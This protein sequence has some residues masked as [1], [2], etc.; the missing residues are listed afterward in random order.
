[1]NNL[2]MEILQSCEQAIRQTISARRSFL[3]GGTQK[4]WKKLHCDQDCKSSIFKLF[5]SYR[6]F[7][8][9]YFFGNPGHFWSRV[10]KNDPFWGHFGSFWVTRDQKAVGNFVNF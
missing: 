6:N 5:I 4:N 1:M 7:Y 3:T 8:E 2:K 10:T 9:K